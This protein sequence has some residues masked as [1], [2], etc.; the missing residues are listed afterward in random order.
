MAFGFDDISI[1]TFIGAGSKCT[2]DMSVAGFVRIDGDVEGNIETTGKIIIGEGA[3]VLGNVHAK[4]VLIGGLVLGNI[5]AEQE[6]N[7][8]STATLIGDLVSPKVQ[9]EQGVVFQ[10]T[11]ISL[12]NPELFEEAKK[13][14][15]TKISIESRA[16][17]L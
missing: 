14:W 10:G 3:R 6:T 8:F 9:F 16:L 1:N 13:D 2:G 7:L 4:Q 12:Q 5:V 15:L 11:C 17:S